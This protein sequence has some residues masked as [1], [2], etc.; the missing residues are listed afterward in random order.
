MCS[1]PTSQITFGDYRQ[2]MGI[3]NAATVQWSNNDRNPGARDCRRLLFERSHR[4][5]FKS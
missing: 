2:I 3:D 5:A 1:A 4:D